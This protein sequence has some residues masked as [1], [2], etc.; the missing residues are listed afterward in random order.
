MVA[1]M[2]AEE[3]DYLVHLTS[4]EVLVAFLG[5]LTLVVSY[6]IRTREQH[7]TN[8]RHNEE[9]RY[10]RRQVTP[11]NGK[12]LAETVESHTTLLDLLKDGQHQLGQR[13]D[14]VRGDL[15]VLTLSN[16]KD[17]EAIIKEQG[18]VKDQLALEAGRMKEQV[19]AQNGEARAKTHAEHEDLRTEAESVKEEIKKRADPRAGDAHIHKR[20][21]DGPRRRRK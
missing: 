9:L 17:H 21:T 1:T 5:L 8:T 13:V 4:P 6:A 20:S 15:N 10:M 16:A 3:I 14:Q 11:Q 2:I 18:R 7:R 12:T 19:L